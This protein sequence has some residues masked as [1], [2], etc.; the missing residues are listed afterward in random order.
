MRA[1][2]R[3]MLSLALM[4]GVA[5]PALADTPLVPATCKIPGAKSIT[6]GSF[7]LNAG[8]VKE[9]KQQHRFPVRPPGAKVN[10]RAVYRRA[11]LA[12]LVSALAKAPGSSTQA[13]RIAIPEEKEFDGPWCGIVDDWHYMALK[14]AQECD[15]LAGG[16]GRAYFKADP[17]YSKFNDPSNHHGPYLTGTDDSDIVLA[18]SCNICVDRISLSTATAIPALRTKIQDVQ[19]APTKE[20]GVQAPAKGD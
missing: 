2:F 10:A 7:Q 6:I 17:S 12:E 13:A 3:F 19:E 9:F 8:Q 11:T 5:A 20:T 15:K 1:P 4:L 18:G 16:S 14:A